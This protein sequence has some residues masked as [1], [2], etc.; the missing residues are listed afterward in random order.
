MVT[1][2]G[3]FCFTCNQGVVYN[4][5]NLIDDDGSYDV[6][7]RSTGAT[8]QFVLFTAAYQR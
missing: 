8:G 1:P 4:P 6:S 7:Y 3:N 2:V 5:E